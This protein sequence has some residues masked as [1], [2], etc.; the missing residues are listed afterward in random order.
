M[1]YYWIIDEK[2]GDVFEEK[3]N[4]ET[5]EEALEIATAEWNHLGK[6]DQRSRTSFALAHAEEDEYGGVDYDSMT[7]NW[8]Q[9]V[10]REL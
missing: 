8:Y 2:R 10:G 7:E 9:F 3:L 6:S 5:F 1:K 4:A